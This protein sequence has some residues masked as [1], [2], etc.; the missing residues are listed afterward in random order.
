MDTSSLLDEEGFPGVKLA[1][2]YGSGA[3]RQAGYASSDQPMLDLILVVDDPV[4]WHAENLSRNRDHY[5]AVGSLGPGFV[6]YLQRLPAGVYYNTLIPM[7]GKSSAG[8]LMKYGVVGRNELVQDLED[9]RWLYLAGRLHKPVLFAAGSPS[10][11]GLEQPVRANLE[12]AVR[13]SLLSLPEKFSQEDLFMTIAGLSY[14]GDFRMVFG[15]NPDK[16][17]N[18]VAPNI[19]RFEELF[20]P[21]LSSTFSEACYWD[22]GTSLWTQ[23]ASPPQILKHCSLLPAAIRPSKGALLSP[24]EAKARLRSVVSRSSVSQSAK[25]F[26]SAGPVKS[27]KYTAAKVA[28]WAAWWLPRLVR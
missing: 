23:D 4:A 16:V 3:V 22:Q 5:S 19:G 20:S 12:A 8:R 21:V 9:W 2:A 14:A 11:A 6:S 17:R 18:I 7:K 13:A 28:K 25:G 10:S 1:I 26:L 27:G 15:E 24:S